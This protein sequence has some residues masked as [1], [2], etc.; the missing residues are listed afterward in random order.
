M[1]RSVLDPFSRCWC[2]CCGWLFTAC[3][4]CGPYGL[5]GCHLSPDIAPTSDVT[6]SVG[7]AKERVILP[8]HPAKPLGQPDLKSLLR[9]PLHLQPPFLYE[10]RVAVVG[11]PASDSTIALV[12]SPFKETAVIDGVSGV[13]EDLT[14]PHSNGFPSTSQT[15]ASSHIERGQPSGRENDGIS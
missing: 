14:Y 1:R 7:Q 8:N 3:F 6:N 11:T 4:G 5:L 13:A 15:Q 10:G 12:A 9:L 2:W